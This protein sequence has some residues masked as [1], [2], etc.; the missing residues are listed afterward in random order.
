MGWPPHSCL[1][2]FVP[3]SCEC[4]IGNTRRAVG[5]DEMRKAQW[6]LIRPEAHSAHMHMA[7]N[8]VLLKR[9]IT[10]VRPAT[11]RLWRCIEPALVIGSHQSVMNEGDTATAHKTAL[12]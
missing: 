8:E 6:D 9:V 1:R 12:P 3:A 10:G 2:D 4:A 5:D 11:M 7:R